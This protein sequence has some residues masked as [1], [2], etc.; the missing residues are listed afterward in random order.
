MT[1]TATA[2]AP[3]TLE[4]FDP[5]E[6]VMDA[7]S[8]TDAEESVTAEDVASAKAHAAT[9]PGFPAHSDP[10]RPA[11]CGNE[12]PIEIRRRPDGSLRVRD[13]RRRNIMCQRAGVAVLGYIA[14]DEGDDTADARP[15][16]RPAG[17]RAGL[18]GHPEIRSP[19]SFPALSEIMRGSQ[20]PPQGCSR[21]MTCGL[22]GIMCHY[23]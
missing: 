9:S 19:M 10:A 11:Q 20:L 8:R 23:L 13:G 6:L 7:N 21:R 5:A 17:G 12:V 22:S 14:S 2:A 15:E 3:I 1:D 4:A 18:A 16:A